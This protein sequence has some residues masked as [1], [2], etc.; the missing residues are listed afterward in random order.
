MVTASAL[1]LVN[2]ELVKLQADMLLLKTHTHNYVAPLLP[3]PAQPGIT[4]PSAALVGITPVLPVPPVA[5]N[6][7]GQTTGG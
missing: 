3:A 2:I 6:L 1:Q 7:T 5:P 4:T